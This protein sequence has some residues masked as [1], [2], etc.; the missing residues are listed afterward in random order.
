MS[1]FA[2][3]AIIKLL[4]GIYLLV[5]LTIGVRALLRIAA[6]LEKGKEDQ[7]P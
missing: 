1:L 7:K 3:F 6:A 4:A 5:L 2:I